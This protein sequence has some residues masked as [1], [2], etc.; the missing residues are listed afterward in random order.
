M[1]VRRNL[2]NEMLNPDYIAGLV[3]GEGSFT[4]Y[5]KNLQNNKEIERRTRAEPKFYIKLIEKDKK[6]LYDLKEYFACGNVYFQKDMRPN[7]QNCYRYEVTKRDDLEKIIIPFF[8]KNKL[9]FNSKK[10]DFNI[11]CNLMERIKVGEHL[12]DA[13]LKRMLKIKQKMH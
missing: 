8:K 12:T 6:I 5:I 9:Q 4:V 11:F 13:G 10:N 2:S 7:H 1:N 3:D